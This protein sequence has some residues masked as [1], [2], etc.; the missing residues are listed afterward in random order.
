MWSIPGRIDVVSSQPYLISS[1][2]RLEVQEFEIVGQTHGA[3]PHVFQMMEAS[4]S[5][6][7]HIL[8]NM[9]GHAQGVKAV[10]GRHRTI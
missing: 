8:Y 5:E 10:Q 1:W 3:I 4:F 6:H 9:I 7:T 2:Y